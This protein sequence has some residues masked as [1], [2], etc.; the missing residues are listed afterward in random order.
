MPRIILCE[1]NSSLFFA[2]AGLSIPFTDFLKFLETSATAFCSSGLKALATS[3][4]SLPVSNLRRNPWILV[5]S[6]AGS[7]SPASSTLV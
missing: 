3:S 2:A 7:S 1:M 4:I 5:H 6:S